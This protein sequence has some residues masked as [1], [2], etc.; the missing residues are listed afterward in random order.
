MLRKCLKLFARYLPTFNRFAR[1]SNTKLRNSLSK[2][3]VHQARR[4]TLSANVKKCEI[5][6]FILRRG[7]V[8]SCLT[9]EPPHRVKL[10]FVGD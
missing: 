9:P 8:C 5:C 10:P 7:L 6:M 4:L 1:F 2:Y 3:Q